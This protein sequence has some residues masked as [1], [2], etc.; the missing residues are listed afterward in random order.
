MKT[1][2]EI[3]EI[4]EAF[5][6]T[7]S[8]RSAA[9]LAGC[10]HH[11]VRRYV[12]AR[13]QGRSVELMRPESL[14]DPFLGKVEEWVERA[15]GRIGADVVHD[16][17]T[18]MGYAG[19]Q[20]TTRRAVSAAKKALRAG[21]RRVYR[22]WIPEPGL[23]LQFD[24]GYGPRIGGR[25]TY[26]W[27]AWL[28]WSRFRVVLPT[29]D[30][31][32]G[33]VVTCLD[34]TL[35]RLGGVPTYALTDNEKTVTVDHVA[36]LA[37]RHPQIVAASRHY[38]LTVHTC[39][40]AD[41]ESKG[42]SEATVRLAKRD[43][44]PTEVNLREGYASFAE[45]R[46]A[47]Q[48]FC[49]EVNGRVHRE[50]GRV[51]G[52]ALLDEQTRLHP[53]PNEPYAVAFGQ[54]RRVMWDSTISMSGVRYSVP[55]EL[56]DER[57]W[58]RVDGDEV[59]ITHIDT[60]GP[61]EVARHPRAGKG[62]PQISDEHYPTRSGDPTQRAPRARRADEAEFLAIGDGAAQWLAEAAAAGTVRIRAKMAEAI[63]L[64]KLYGAPAVDRAL[65]TA[66]V[67]GRFGEAD[68]GSILAHQRHRGHADSAAADGE[69][70]RAGET[71]SLQPGTAAWAGFGKEDHQ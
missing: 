52:E 28:A 7:G 18:A 49:D 71:H 6:L 3:M 23:W 66:A 50:T 44:V 8:Y 34:A 32:L 10:D 26:L 4:L 63:S 33:E 60:R 40:P 22:P 39:L 67:S 16:K 29:W 13:G 53:L 31:S 36:T 48:A 17:L 68:L 37:V 30:R 58:A 45:L 24:W 1:P 38:G 69:P 35:R 61:A 21:K 2:E 55:H 25:R 27:C 9:E 11:T 14:I 47:C 19:S 57:V 65:G 15:H 70:I 56:I 20:R 59:V 43:L 64:A 46:S 51:P 62:D 41:P 54:T 42:G 12:Q 5:D